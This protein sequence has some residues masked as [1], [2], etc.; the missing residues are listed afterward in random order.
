M[1]DGVDSRFN[2]KVKAVSIHGTAQCQNFIIL[3][4]ILNALSTSRYYLQ[5][6]LN[7]AQLRVKAVIPYMISVSEF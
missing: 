6:H 2:Y 1:T 7:D 3:I 5:L 4:P